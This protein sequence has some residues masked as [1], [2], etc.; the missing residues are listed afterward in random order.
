MYNYAW[1]K[2][3]FIERLM[4][5]RKLDVLTLS[6]TKLKGRKSLVWEKM[7]GIKGGV[8]GIQRAR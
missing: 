4:D 5:E 2:R 7:S 3:K 1:D 6:K 8:R